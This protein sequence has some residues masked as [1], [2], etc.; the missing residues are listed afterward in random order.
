MYID[1][2]ELF[3]LQNFGEKQYFFTFTDNFTKYTEIYTKIQKS[4]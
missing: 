3:I 4:N 1:L 2:V